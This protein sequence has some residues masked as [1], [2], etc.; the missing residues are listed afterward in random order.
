M[1]EVLALG[2]PPDIGRLMEIAA[3]CGLI[4]HMERLEEVMQAHNVSLQ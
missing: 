3:R 1:A 2:G 4:L